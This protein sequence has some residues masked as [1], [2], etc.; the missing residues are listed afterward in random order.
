MA[1]TQNYKEFQKLSFKDIQTLLIVSEPTAKRY[2]GDI[3]LHFKIDA[4]LYIHF[5]KYF[6][7]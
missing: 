2:L 6:N 4:V 7:C 1:D 5:K 3:K